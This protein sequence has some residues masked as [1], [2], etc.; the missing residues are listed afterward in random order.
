MI[1]GV[2]YQISIDQMIIVTQY[3]FYFPENESLEICKSCSLSD[4]SEANVLKCIKDVLEILIKLLA[5]RY[6]EMNLNM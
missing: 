6:I 2:F 3:T 5:K 4:L 1:S